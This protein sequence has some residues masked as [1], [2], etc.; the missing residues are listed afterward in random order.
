MKHWLKKGIL[1]LAIG[2]LAFAMT[3]CQGEKVLDKVLEKTDPKPENK[4]DKKEEENTTAPETEVD[5]P[6]LVQNIEGSYSYLPGS[7]A[8]PL[9][10]EARTMDNGV[11]T[12]QWYQNQ[13]NTN[14]GGTPIEGEDKATFTPPTDTEGTLYYYVVATNTIGSSTNGITSDTVEII[15]SPDVKEE[16]AGEWKQDDKGWWYDNGDGTFPK[17]EWK[18]IDDAWYAF[19]ESGY[20]RTGWFKDGNDW[21]YLQNNGIMATDTDV[22]GYHLGSNGKME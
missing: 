4:E 20:M 7:E 6:E 21:Y 15:V 14:G 19:D 1:I 12:Y 17:N 22:E 3:G 10:V 13:T 16:T 5:K 9:K 18:L 2:C 11:I 8:E